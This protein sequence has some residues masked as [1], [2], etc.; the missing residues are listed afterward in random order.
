MASVDRDADF[1]E[2]SILQGRNGVALL[3][4]SSMVSSKIPYSKNNQAS[5]IQNRVIVYYS[6]IL[7]YLTEVFLK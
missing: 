6:Y 4:R 2:I 5:H 7:C 1:F 3:Q